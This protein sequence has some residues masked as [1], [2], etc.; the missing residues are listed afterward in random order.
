[1]DAIENS[2]KN[3]SV[4]S[5]ERTIFQIMTDNDMSEDEANKTIDNMSIENM[6]QYL[7]DVRD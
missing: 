4:K 7:A 5:M 3:E 1:M 6:E 2:I